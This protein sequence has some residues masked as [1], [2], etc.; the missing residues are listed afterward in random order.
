[1]HSINQTTNLN[2]GP[3]GRFWGRLAGWGQ[4]YLRR[5]RNSRRQ[6]SRTRQVVRL[7]EQLDDRLLEDVI[8]LSRN[9]I[10][11]ALKQP[12]G[13]ATRVI[14]Q[15]MREAGRGVNR[16]PEQIYFSARQDTKFVFS[17][18]FQ[19]LTRFTVIFEKEL[20]ND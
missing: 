14:A 3:T 16:K 17:P 20:P 8:G 15:A 1:M 10:E 11:S 7:F 19:E 5:H 13:E 4:A 6:R 18:S 9:E 12:G 2:A